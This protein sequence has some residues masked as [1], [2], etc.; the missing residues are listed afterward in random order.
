MGRAV[1]LIDWTVILQSIAKHYCHCKKKA[2]KVFML[3]EA[4]TGGVL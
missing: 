2:F 3:T 4:A 1:Q